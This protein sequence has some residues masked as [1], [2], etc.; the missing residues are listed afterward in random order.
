M[1]DELDRMW[2][3]PERATWLCCVSGFELWEPFDNLKD[4]L[5]LTGSGSESAEAQVE[6]RTATNLRCAGSNRRVVLVSRTGF[7]WVPFLSLFA[8]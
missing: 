4:G 3:N 6:R 1:Q 2:H 5:F 8:R 7:W